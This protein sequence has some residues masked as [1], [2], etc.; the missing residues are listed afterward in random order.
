MKKVVVGAVTILVIVVGLTLLV[1]GNEDTWICTN[2]NWVKHGHPSAPMPTKPC[3]QPT[4]PTPTVNPNANIVLES[5]KAGATLGS[6]F[7]IKGKARVFENKL[8]FRIRNAKG[9]SLIEGT[10]A[11]Q[12]PD[13]GKFGPFEATVSSLPAGKT[14]IEVFDHSAKDGSEIDKVSIQV[15]VK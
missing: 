1:R 5:P 8:N 10:M 9:Q 15:T 4:S 6:S 11:A 3:V 13:A 7:V 2:G 12:S 14:T